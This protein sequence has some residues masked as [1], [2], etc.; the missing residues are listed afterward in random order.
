MRY[1]AII[2]LLT[3]MAFGANDFTLDDNCVALWRFES[4][5]LTTDSKGTNTLVAGGTPTADT[6]D[7]QEGSAS[8]EMGVLDYYLI[9]DG[10][11][12]AGFP[13]KDGDANKKISMC[14]WVYIDSGPDVIFYKWGGDGYRSLILDNGEGKFRLSLGYNA[15]QTVSL[16]KTASWTSG[17]WYHIGLTYQDSDKSWRLRIWDKTAVGLLGGV[18]YTGT[19]PENI[20]ISDGNFEIGA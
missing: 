17:R 5:A 7:Y 6:S 15:T 18:E 12:D 1:F 13:L 20:Y 2:L 14:T 3:T 4:G 10:N 11:L 16:V 19:S 9:T 8:V